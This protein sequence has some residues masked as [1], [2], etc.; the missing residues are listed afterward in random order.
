MDGLLLDAETDK[1]RALVATVSIVLVI[2]IIFNKVVERFSSEGKFWNSQ[3]WT[4]LRS[5]WL[6]G[7]RAYFR[8]FVT[9]RDMLDSGYH[10]VRARRGEHQNNELSFSY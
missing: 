2:S 4:G 7:T 1:T 9:V 5:E 6:A 3:P 8:S 10:K